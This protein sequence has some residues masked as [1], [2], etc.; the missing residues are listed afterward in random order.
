MKQ[1]LR[2]AS[3][4]FFAGVAVFYFI[5]L[6]HVDP[7]APLT[8]NVLFDLLV[9]GLASVFSWDSFSAWRKARN[10]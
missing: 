4:L 7:N 9:P 2:F 6:A 8:L 5:A 1:A 3:A 10:N